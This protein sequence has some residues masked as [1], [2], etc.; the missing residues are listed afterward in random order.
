MKFV[1]RYTI[2][3]N[4]SV[5]PWPCQY[6]PTSKIVETINESIHAMVYACRI[7][8]HFELNSIRFNPLLFIYLIML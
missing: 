3:I 8:A 2:Y 4:M 1:C 6:K 7:P 5:T